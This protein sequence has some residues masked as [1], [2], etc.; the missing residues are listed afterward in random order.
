MTRRPA[1][2][3]ARVAAPEWVRALRPSVTHVDVL[4]TRDGAAHVVGLTGRDGVPL[5]LKRYENGHGEQAVRADATVAVA[6]GLDGQTVEFDREVAVIDDDEVITG[7]VHF[8]K[9]EEHGGSGVCVVN[10]PTSAGL[11]QG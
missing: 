11:Q 2:A 10:R 3:P 9:V 4:G 5:V 8:I 1:A 7:T 6:E